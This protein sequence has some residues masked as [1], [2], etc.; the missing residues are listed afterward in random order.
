MGI[1]SK[2]YYLSGGRGEE[3]QIV[4]IFWEGWREDSTSY[5]FLEGWGRLNNLSF[6]RAGG[7]LNNSYVGRAGVL[8]FWEGGG[9]GV[10]LEK[11]MYFLGGLGGEDSTESLYFGRA[12]GDSTSY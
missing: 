11:L 7:R 9:G 12:G 4:F 5:Y 10:I 6:G 3:T 8:I 2:S 1:D